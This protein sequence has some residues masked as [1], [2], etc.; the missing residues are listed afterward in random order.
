MGR[1]DEE[2]RERRWKSEMRDESAT[3]LAFPL[4]F[5]PS[6]NSLLSW[7][8][9]WHAKH[10]K[11]RSEG[12]RRCVCLGV[13]MCYFWSLSALFREWDGFENLGL[14]FSPDPTIDE[15]I[16]KRTDFE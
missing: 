12:E 14:S 5:L 11:V 2:V 15:V 9:S 7:C 10:M 16:H 3:P 8:I 13:Y 6:A 4:S 1:G